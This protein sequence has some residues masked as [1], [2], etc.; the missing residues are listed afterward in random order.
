M[1][2]LGTPK[3]KADG[4]AKKA[5]RSGC[6]EGT[7][8]FINIFA[9]FSLPEKL[10]IHFT[11]T[12]N[13]LLGMQL[14]NFSKLLLTALESTLLQGSLRQMGSYNQSPLP[15]PTS[16]FTHW[17]FILPRG[18]HRNHFIHPKTEQLF[19]S[20]T[21]WQVRRQRMPYPVE[22]W[23]FLGKQNPSCVS[24]KRAETLG[25]IL[26]LQT[27]HHATLPDH[28]DLAWNCPQSSD[29]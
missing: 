26:L 27:Q 9:F 12:E 17:K 28:W 24:W 22:T 2:H 23:E 5:Q 8:P 16:P 10:S 3:R 4:T 29:L 20:S 21:A 18:L 25:P 6:T 7:C 19:S 13:Y 15:S 11:Y 14:N 1:A